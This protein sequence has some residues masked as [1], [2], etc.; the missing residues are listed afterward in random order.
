VVEL[1]VA[2][3]MFCAH[4]FAAFLSTDKL[5][6]VEL[7]LATTTAL[8]TVFLVGD[9]FTCDNRTTNDTI[10]PQVNVLEFFGKVLEFWGEVLGFWGLR[11]PFLLA[12]APL[13]A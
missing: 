11:A 9:D 2:D 6:P 12:R 4:F 7:L 13:R 5:A 3:S 8:N 1:F 10:R